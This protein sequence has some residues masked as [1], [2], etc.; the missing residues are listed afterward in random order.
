MSAIEDR[1][2]AS[3]SLVFA[4]PFDPETIFSFCLIRKVA[5]FSRKLL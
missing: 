3:Q 1:I 4:V 5:D 2:L